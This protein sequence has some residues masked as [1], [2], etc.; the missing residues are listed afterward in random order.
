MI[1][2]FRF[3]FTLG[4]VLLSFSQCFS[5]TDST[6][7]EEHE[8]TERIKQFHADILIKENGNIVVTE[9]ITVY[10]AQQEIDH[11]IFR[12]LP[13]KNYS[14]KVSRNNFYTILNVTKDWIKEPYH[15]D[16]D[17]ENFKIYIGDKDI[18][19]SE[20]TYTYKLTYEVEAQIHSYDNFDEVYWNVTGNYWQFDIENV[21]AKVILPSGT[22]ALQTHC[23]TGILGSKQS[24]CDSKIGGTS[25]Y[26][27]SK[28]LKKEEGFTVAVGFPKGIVYQPFFLPHYKIEEFVSAEKLFLG[29]LAVSICLLF[30]YFSWKK[31]GEDPLISNESNQFID[32]KNHHTATSLLYIKERYSNSKTLL[33]AIISLSI[34]VAIEITGNGFQTWR[35]EFEYYL[36]KG[37]KTTNLAPEENAVL[38]VFFK[39]SDTFAINSKSYTIFSQ[40]EKMLEKSLKNQ[41]N[42]KDYFLSNLKQILIA[43]II[44]IITIVTYS[45]L[46]VGTALIFVVIGFTSLNLTAI[47]LIV[48]IKSFIKRQFSVAFPCMIVAIFPAAFTFASFFAINVD[49]NYSAL[50]ALVIFLIV[51]GFTIFLSLINSYTKLGLVTKIQIEKFKQHLLNYPVEQSTNIISA[52]EENL[53]YAFALGIEEEWNLKF[54]DALKSL[55]YTSN[56]IKTS[57]GSVGFSYQNI[58]HFYDTYTSSS[59]SSSSGSSGG[60]SSGGG[61][62]GGGGGGW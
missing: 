3:L 11:G 50:N 18:S 43:S 52:Y 51:T 35:E 42:L 12:Q 9:T 16:I 22:S 8:R 30:Y 61:G 39:E 15:T 7:T 24:E 21:S 48:I 54:S 31:Y 62:G 58:T 27:T 37:S 56:W 32:I 46:T 20:G 57:D 10:A 33:V 5:Q 1:R 44:T 55:N 45:Y 53:P 59:S 4:L 14:S 41:H 29:L 60:G 34:K 19:L 28:N 17:G 40:A 38:D 25:V 36:V 49:K 13:M 47:L 23:Y 2:H 6:L 26:F